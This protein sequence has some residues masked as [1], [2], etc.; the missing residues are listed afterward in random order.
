MRSMIPSLALSLLG[1]LAACAS[2]PAPA[3]QP[4]PVTLMAETSTNPDWKALVPAPI[5]T[6]IPNRHLEYALTWFGLAVTLV[7]IFGVFVWT[8]RRA[9]P[10]ERG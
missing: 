3:P 7:A 4:A 5:P 2:T 6:D 9:T 1:A 8:R 10:Q